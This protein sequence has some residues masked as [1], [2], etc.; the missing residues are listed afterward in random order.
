MKRDAGIARAR[1]AGFCDGAHDRLGAVAWRTA[2]IARD[3]LVMVA[4][5]RGDDRA[6]V[7]AAEVDPEK[8]VVAQTLGSLPASSGEE[9]TLAS[10]SITLFWA[11][12]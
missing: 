3:D 7:R 9:R 4:L 8:V 11:A 2:L 12:L 1:A 10:P 5:E 6:D